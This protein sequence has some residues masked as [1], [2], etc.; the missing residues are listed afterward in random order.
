MRVMHKGRAVKVEVTADGTGVISHAGAALVAR[1]ADR[2]GLVAAL[3]R[4]LLELYEREPTHTPGK[5]LVDL[6][7]T[8]LDGGDCPADVHAQR[9]QEPLFGAVASD[10]TMYRVIERIAAAPDGLELIDQALAETRA[11][12][13]RRGARP[14]RVVID[15]DAT[16]IDSHSEKQGATP[17]YKRGFGFHPL[18]AYVDGTGEPVA[19]VLREG[20]ATANDGADQ[21]QTLS[22]ALGQL[23]KRIAARE[24]ILVRADSAGCVR[25]LLAFC[26]DG[27]LRF[28]VGLPLTEPVR[29][30]IVEVPAQRWT[31]AIE[32]DGTPRE[33]DGAMV[34]ELTDLLDTT[35]WPPA[36]RVIVRREEA[37]PGAQFSFTDHDGHRF[38]AVLT[39]QP[40]PDIAY[41]EAR[42]RGH[43]RVED[44]IRAAKD[45]GLT[46][47]PFRD[48]DM[49]A[50]WLKIVALAQ[51][52]LAWTQALCLDGDL[53]RAEP[54][55][56]RFRLLHTAGRLCF[57]AGRATLRLAADW[58]YSGQLAA[59]F[60]RLE[61]LPAAT[62]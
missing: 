27:N 17:T 33:H 45:T 29:A 1:L 51:N 56:L 23:P 25:E 43:A 12:V 49:N 22:G 8:L 60:A 54:K 15:V 18:L 37:H 31:T 40:D 6:A 2:V 47:L 21:I 41:L 55:R 19:G 57:H 13:W 59:A 14:R 9:E 42:H 35:G 24:E 46:N 53:A 38:Q 44:H 5:A 61:A 32:Q 58:P 10:S 3:D 20:C 52:L 50:V 16:L 39:D 62:R 36:S 48:F 30:A 4:R 7:V 28:S 11:R 34:C 26:H